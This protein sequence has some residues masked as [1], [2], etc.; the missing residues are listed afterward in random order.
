MPIRNKVIIAGAGPGDPELITYKAIKA[1]RKAD[2]VITDRL[3]SATILDLYVSKE[4]EIIFGGKQR[5][6]DQSAQQTDIN[7]LLVEF[8]LAGKQVV[9]LKGGDVSIFS[10]IFDELQ[11]LK[12]NKIPY[13]IIPGIT[14]ASGAA[15]YSGIPLTARSH[16]S[17]VRFL[18][19]HKQ[20]SFSEAYWKELAET[21]DTLVFYMTGNTIDDLV[22]RLTFHRIDPKKS[23]AVIEQ[24]TTPLQNVRIYNFYRHKTMPLSEIISPSLIIIGKVVNLHRAFG[25]IKNYT[26]GAQYFSKIEENPITSFNQQT[27][28]AS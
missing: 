10:N 16:A 26:G 27:L 23:M 8:A 17:A 18:A 4:A 5:A 1:L 7:Q 25:W 14:A 9:R 28:L 19:Y 15:A 2:V 24:A 22:A 21:N 3:V 11:E 12:K 13:E 6:N 20:G